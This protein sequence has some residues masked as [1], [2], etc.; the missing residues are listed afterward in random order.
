MDSTIDS[1]NPQHSYIYLDISIYIYLDMFK[2]WS[3]LLSLTCSQSDKG[4]MSHKYYIYAICYIYAKSHDEKLI[5]SHTIRS[6]LMFYQNKIYSNHFY[7]YALTYLRYQFI[8]N[9]AKLNLINNLYIS[10][11]NY[12]ISIWYFILD[13]IILSSSKW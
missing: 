5:L 7:V 1:S 4:S 9:F 2:P 6:F 10:I 3:G 13:L 12:K 8:T 11:L